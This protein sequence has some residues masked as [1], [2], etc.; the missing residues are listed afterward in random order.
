M[1]FE[2]TH[3]TGKGR[4]KPMGFPTINLKIPDDFGLKDGIYAAKVTI[5]NKKFI[6]ALHFGPVP[7]FAEQEKSLEVYLISAHDDLE[8][9]NLDGKIIKIEIVKYLRGII[10]FQSV[11][12]LVK[13][14]E[15]DVKQ[16]KTLIN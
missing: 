7:T 12:S 5:E 13:Q 11:T 2:S 6:G 16:I 8:L 9:E 1:Q 14:I 10:K 3:I 4:G 15:E